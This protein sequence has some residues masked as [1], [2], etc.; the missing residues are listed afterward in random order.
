MYPSNALTTPRQCALSS[1]ESLDI[2]CKPSAKGSLIGLLVALLAADLG[3]AP[4]VPFL[5][6]R[7][8]VLPIELRFVSRFPV[9][10]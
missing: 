5:V 9:L 2:L 1:G 3:I 6:A 7:F 8:V 10:F 4:V